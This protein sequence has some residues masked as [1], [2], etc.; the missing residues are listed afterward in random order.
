[1]ILN[2]TSFIKHF[3]S[4]SPNLGS[5]DSPLWETEKYL[6]VECTWFTCIR[7]VHNFY[8]SKDAYWSWVRNN[9]RGEV[10]CYSSDDKDEEWWG[11]THRADIVMFLLKWSS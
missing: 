6:G 10:I 7:P 3:N 4:L 9:C 2:R 5:S 11:F 1:M 8:E